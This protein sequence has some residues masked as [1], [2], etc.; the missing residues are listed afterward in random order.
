MLGDGDESQVTASR[1][2]LTAGS[3]KIFPE[4]GDLANKSDPPQIFGISN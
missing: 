2:Y 3:T 4:Y 1:Q